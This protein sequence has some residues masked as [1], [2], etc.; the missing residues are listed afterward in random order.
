MMK[1][2]AAIL[3]AAFLLASCVSSPKAQDK[4]PDWALNTPSPDGTYTY[5]V[6][7]S[8]DNAGSEALAAEGATA[9]L[10]SSIM[11][12]IGVKITVDSSATARASYDSYQAEVVQTVKTQSTNRLSGF[13]V[14]ERHVIKDKKTS[15]VTVYILASYLTKDLEA[16]KTRIQKLFQEQIDAVAI[17][18]S[19]GKSQESAG[20]YFE[21]VQSYIE[22]AVAA[23]GAD[24]DNADIKM[25][26]N[27]NNARRVLQRLR[28]VGAG[29]APTA[30][31]GKPFSGPFTVKLVYGE[32]DS[33]SG[34]GIPGVEVYVTYQVRQASG[35]LTGKTD[36][37][38]SDSKGVLS[39]TP[40]PPNFVGKAK[41]VMRLNLDSSLALLDKFPAQFDAHRQSLE[42]ELRG[43]TAEFEYSVISMAK[44][45]ATGIAIIELDEKGEALASSQAQS[46]L[47]EALV[48]EKF[49]VQAAP[50][51]AALL[52]SG[53]D[54]AV[55]AAA[56]AAYKAKLT[57]IV[58]GVARIESVRKDGTS[59]VVSVKA[60][61]KCWDLGS[62]QILYSAEKAYTGVG[63]DEAAA[64]RASLQQL[65]RDALGKDLMAN[66][67]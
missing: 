22:A 50:L 3:F 9:N 25:E 30:G 5:F 65:G 13:M 39:F 61:V 44:D 29:A 51:D 34:S 38:V 66:L 8:A 18:E 24:I 54:A 33:G 26:R 20:R 12:Y 10:L 19:R 52:K 7:Y 36:R 47:L 27:V 21:A 2:H 43:R 1:R 63:P 32:D 35:R 49:K 60:S 14:K 4:A 23:S 62:G 56:R 42:A 58:A 67:P 57:R 41:L 59:F 64:R 17:P 55:L 37:A 48:K 15:R 40:P 11:N 53:D 45:A 28:F 16:E 46:G 31:L 6:G